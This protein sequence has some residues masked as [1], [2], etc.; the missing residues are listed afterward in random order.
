MSLTNKDLQKIE[1]LVDKKLDEKLKPIIDD[2]LIIRETVNDLCFFVQQ[3]F[4]EV[5]QNLI[6]NRK[7]IE[8]IKQQL[9]MK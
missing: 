8:Q 7:D 2:I 1:E 5:D 6:A 4:Y 3:R 9:G